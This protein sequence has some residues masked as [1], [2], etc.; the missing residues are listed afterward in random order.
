MKEYRELIQVD[1]DFYRLLSPFEGNDTAWMVVAR[2]KSQAVAAFYQRMNKVNAS[3]L[4]LKLQGLDADTLY[5]VSCD[6]APSASYDDNIAKIYGLRTDED[7]VKTYCAYGDELM[8]VGIPIDR[9]DLNKKGGD[10]ASLLYTL[11]KVTD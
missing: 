10:F 8:Q 9:E 6:L 1:G 2:D 4:R 3:W 5:E 7:M 11:K